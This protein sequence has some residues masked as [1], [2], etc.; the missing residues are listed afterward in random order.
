MIVVRRRVYEQRG[1]LRD[2]RVPVLVRGAAPLR[3]CEEALPVVLGKR[4]VT[5][6]WS[7]T[8]PERLSGTMLM[9]PL[10]PSCRRMLLET[11]LSV[12]RF[13]MLTAQ[14]PSGAILMVLFTTTLFMAP[15]AASMRYR[16]IPEAWLP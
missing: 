7:L 15:S 8:K 9:A 13:F 5:A 11:V 14:R 12:L 16:E 1:G 6:L 4:F 2:E 10:W 3:E